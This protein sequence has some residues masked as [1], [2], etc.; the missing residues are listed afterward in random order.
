MTKL[1]GNGMTAVT[2]TTMSK[3]LEW[4]QLKK[5]QKN[6]ETLKAKKN[7]CNAILGQSISMKN[8]IAPF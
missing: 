1:L 8:K 6:T 4:N 5:K 7:N 2:N 3:L